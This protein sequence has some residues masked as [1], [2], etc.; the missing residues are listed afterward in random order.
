MTLNES[1]ENIEKALNESA[2][3]YELHKKY[4]CPSCGK[5]VEGCELERYGG[6]CME[7]DY[8]ENGSLDESVK[9][10]EGF[11]QGLQNIGQNIKNN[12][13]V[14]GTVKSIGQGISKAVNKAAEKEKSN[15]VQSLINNVSDYPSMARACIAIYKKFINDKNIDWSV[16]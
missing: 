11:A 9:F 6:Q 4:K 15:D 16:L 5:E 10:E 13:L 7:C 8:Q 14:G 12:G 2:G 1:L 3:E